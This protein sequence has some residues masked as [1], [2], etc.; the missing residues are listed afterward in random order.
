MT[1]ELVLIAPREPSVAEWTATAHVLVEDGFVFE[2]WGGMHQV[3]DGEREVLSWWPARPVESTRAVELMTGATWDP[4]M[5]WVDV[6]VPDRD[7]AGE[8]IVREVAAI[9]GGTVW[10][11]R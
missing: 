5:H 11:E 1:R 4:S 8:Q 3:V 6:S 10:E 7:G 2:F 9:V